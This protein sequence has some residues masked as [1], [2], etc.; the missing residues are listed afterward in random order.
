MIEAIFKNQVLMTFLIASIWIIPGILFTL[1]TNR[2]Y[3]NRQIE[4]QIK[5]VSKLYPQPKKI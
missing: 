2:K 4:M 3:K 1:A 5:K